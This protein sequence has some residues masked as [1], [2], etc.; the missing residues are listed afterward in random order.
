MLH[1]SECKWTTQWGGALEL[2]IRTGLRDPLY[3]A[4]RDYV[5]V[6]GSGKR[7]VK[8][9]RPAK[10]SEASQPRV[11][12]PL[13]CTPADNREG[14]W[15]ATS[16]RK[17]SSDGRPFVTATDVRES[18]EQVPYLK[19]HSI[20]SQRR[21]SKLAGPDEFSIPLHVKTGTP[22][23]DIEKIQSWMMPAQQKRFKEV[24]THLLW[25]PAKPDPEPKK[26]GSLPLSDISKLIS[27]GVLK[28]VSSEEIQRRPTLQYMVPF[29]V[30]EIDDTGKKRRRFISWTQTDNN[31]LRSYEPHVPLMHPSKYLHRVENEIGV[32]RD[33][34]CGFYQVPIPPKARRKF[35]FVGE[36]GE[37]YEMAV[38]PM[39]HRCA[40]EIMHT[41]TAT[42]AGHM[43]FCNARDSYKPV[44]FGIDVY[45]DGVRFAGTRR[46]AA[47]YATFI[48]RKC[49]EPGALFKDAGSAPSEDYIFNGV[50]YDHAGHKVSLGPKV[51]HKLSMDKF[52][53]VTF[54][55]LE[56]AV[57]RLVYCSAVL[58]IVIPQY[59]FVLKLVQRP[60]N[61]MNRCPWMVTRLVAC[62][63]L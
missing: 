61:L 50:R 28:H 21:S 45:I 62:T 32:K 17:A 55:E 63:L 27:S 8:H 19:K 5:P 15:D 23:L 41:I 59:H 2:N 29:T 11:S 24:L 26:R 44:C 52:Y 56:A 34:S 13:Q 57:G 20:V 7:Q 33:L 37:V 1:R 49:T 14:A 22:L 54:A 9:K 43:E 12:T 16:N 40:P 25:L 48:D 42:I 47:E 53:S 51:V 3:K 6:R 36:D 46:E 30:V 4:R 60:I 38:L 31:R 39:G 10:P 58:G 18:F 35:R